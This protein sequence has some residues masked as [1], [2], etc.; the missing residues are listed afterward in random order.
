VA[1]SV[2]DIPAMAQRNIAALAETAGRGLA[3]LSFNAEGGLLTVSFEG[4]L[5]L[6]RTIEITPAQLQDED[7]ERRHAIFDRLMLELQRSLDHF[8]RQFQF[9][10]VS[11]MVLAPIDAP[12]LPEYLSSN[13]Y[14]PVETL[15]LRTVLDLEAVPELADIGLQHRCFMALGAALRVEEVKL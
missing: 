6:A 14:L 12:G 10:S 3:M 8:E 1:L 13:M 11:R 4:E 15:D 2:I 9:I 7:M 5:Y